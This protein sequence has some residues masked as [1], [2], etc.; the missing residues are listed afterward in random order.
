MK[1][2]IYFKN[3]LPILYYIP[4]YQCVVLYYNTRSIDIYQ[5]ITSMSD[6]LKHSVILILLKIDK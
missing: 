4:F 5:I 1:L 3:E 6:E 2:F